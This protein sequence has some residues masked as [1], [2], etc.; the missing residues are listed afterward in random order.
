MADASIAQNLAKCIAQDIG[1]IL[2]AVEPAN[3]AETLA[4][5]IPDLAAV[6]MKM[7]G[8]LSS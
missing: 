4:H 2:G 3:S 5:E 6:L 8:P 7:A 1:A